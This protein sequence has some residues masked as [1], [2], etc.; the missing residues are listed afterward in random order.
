MRTG[1]PSTYTPEIAEHICKIVAVNPVGLPKLCKMHPE[2]PSYETINVWRWE[3]PDFADKYAL[4]K[5]FQAEMMAESIED[6]CDELASKAYPDENGNYHLDSGLVAH[7]RL[8]IDSRKWTASKL[9]P[10]IYGDKREIEQIQSEN[11]G[12]KAELQALRSQL[13][14]KNKREY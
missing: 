1:R 6:V 11:E 7:A 5:V 12:I 8:V 13:A 14:E 10:K 3:K 4:A 2:F 9:A